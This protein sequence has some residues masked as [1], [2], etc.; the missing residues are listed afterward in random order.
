MQTPTLPGQDNRA[1]LLMTAAAEE[2]HR[3]ALLT[4]RL[5]DCVAELRTAAPQSPALRQ[6]EATLYTYTVAGCAA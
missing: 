5:L 4:L 3:S 1:V 2:R 6:A